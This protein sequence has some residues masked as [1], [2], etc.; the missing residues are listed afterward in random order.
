MGLPPAI[1]VVIDP[2][3]PML[4]LNTDTQLAMTAWS[5]SQPSGAELRLLGK[6]TKY[7]YSHEQNTGARGSE[8]PVEISPTAVFQSRR[9][10]NDFVTL[11]C[12]PEILRY[13]AIGRD[14]HSSDTPKTID[15][16]LNTVSMSKVE[17]DI[18]SE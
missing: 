12:F 1:G 4:A 7:S 3:A 10:D 11:S 8:P 15:P 9:K 18:D 2:A 13:L 16:I 6:Q 5:L 17:V 14:R